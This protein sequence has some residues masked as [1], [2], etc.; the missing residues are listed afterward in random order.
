MTIS[1]QLRGNINSN[2][3][4]KNEK[5]RLTAILDAILFGILPK[6]VSLASISF[7]IYILASQKCHLRCDPVCMELPWNSNLTFIG[8]MMYYPMLDGH[9]GFWQPF[10]HSFWV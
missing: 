9:V 6:D 4:L 8:F 1:V 5:T 7:I 2:I 10:L 3:P